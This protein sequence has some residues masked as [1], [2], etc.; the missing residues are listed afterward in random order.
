MQT[1]VST[2]H[3]TANDLCNVEA[4]AKLIADAAQRAEPLASKFAP[5][6]P[7]ELPASAEDVLPAARRVPDEMVRAAAR[8]CDAAGPAADLAAFSHAEGL[9]SLLGPADGGGREALGPTRR[10][11]C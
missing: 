3:Q 8:Q 6:C 4:R 9:L 5:D 11:R 7:I 2:R 1:T 10:R